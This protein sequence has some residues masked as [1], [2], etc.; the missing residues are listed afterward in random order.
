MA[1]A[2]SL[3][4]KLNTTAILREGALY[5]R[6]LEEELQRSF[7]YMTYYSIYDLWLFTFIYLFYFRLEQLSKGASEPSAFLQWQKEM[8]DKDLQEEL[9]ELERRRLEGRISHE[10]A[11]LA[12]E[13]VLERNYHKAQQTKEEV[14]S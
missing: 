8:K 14:I 5:N 13:R 9:A 3:P 10:E 12:R 4:V 7:E 2:N 1:Q 11:L 6:Q